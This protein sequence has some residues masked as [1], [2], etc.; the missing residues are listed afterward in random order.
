MNGQI[1]ALV[2]ELDQDG[3]SD[4]YL[5][6]SG[7]LRNLLDLTDPADI[8]EAE[9]QAVWSG[10]RRA[11]QF[12]E[13]QERFTFEAWN[14][15]HRILFM[16]LY[17]W[18]GEPRSINMGRESRIVFNTAAEIPAEAQ[19]VLERIER[20]AIFADEMGAFYA[21]MNFQHPFREGNG[22]TLK[23][24][25]SAIA[26]RRGIFIDWTRLDLS[27]YVAALVHWHRTLKP[28]PIQAVLIA[29]SRPAVTG[30]RLA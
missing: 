18:A 26:L 14:T 21:E 6:P 30:D 1:D 27:A 4:S 8:K 13:E 7:V 23:L 16:D 11:I 20:S 17:D 19:A 3:L 2:G 24:L 28:E 15:I 29:C 10:R 12:L 22:R 9:A 25:F 5:A